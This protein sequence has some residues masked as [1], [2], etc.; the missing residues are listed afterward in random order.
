M[1]GGD[2]VVRSGP[3]AVQW[4]APERHLAGASDED[5]VSAA[6]VQVAMFDHLYERYADRLY[7]YALGRTGSQSA[8][9]DIVAETMV[10]ALEHLERFDPAKGSFATW[11]FTIASRRIADRGRARGRLWRYL[12]RRPEPE[13]VEDDPLDTVIRSDEGARVRAAIDRLSDSHREVVLL[14]YVAD[15]PILNIARVLNTTE[16]AV[17][18]RLQRALRNLANDLGDD[19]A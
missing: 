9:D 1:D 15:L 16:G 7:R 10:A 12:R 11:L 5:L 3:D 14:R 4:G 18:M 2:A 13:P 17:K 8:A 19:R 6:L